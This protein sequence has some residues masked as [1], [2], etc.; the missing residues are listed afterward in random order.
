MKLVDFDFRLHRNY[1]KGRA[2]SPETLLLWMKAI[3]KYV[4]GRTRLTILDLGCGTGRF[5]KPIAQYFDTRVLGIE[6]SSK[7]MRI[8][9]RYNGDSRVDYMRGNGESIPVSR[10]K[11]H[12]AFLS[13]VI[14]HLDD[15][16]ATCHE[17]KRVLRD[18]GRVFIRN[19]FSGR[20]DSIPCY[21][22][23]PTAKLID[24][25]RLPT[26]EEIED[27]FSAIGFDILALETIRQEINSSFFD[28]YRRIKTRSFSTFELLSDEEFKRGL[29]LMKVALENQEIHGPI[30]E[31][32]DLLIL[33]NHKDS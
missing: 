18:R 16:G 9:E 10:S 6:P 29:S 2:H 30:K 20:L 12:F 5:S 19:S 27:A 23:F 4:P 17:L 32:I 8:A 15:L 26:V 28:Y 11:C 24:N 7:M 21:R 1:Y 13:M 33:E 25:G 31:D 3:A 22:F 14:H